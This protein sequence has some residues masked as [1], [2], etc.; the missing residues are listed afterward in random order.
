MSTT[1]KK[2]FHSHESKVRESTFR[3]FGDREP[4]S[5]YHKQ[6]ECWNKDELFK[7]SLKTNLV[8]HEDNA[9][10]EKFCTNRYLKSSCK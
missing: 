6:K 8:Q 1:S 7:E 3:D 5:K 10:E 4:F 2:K 9:D